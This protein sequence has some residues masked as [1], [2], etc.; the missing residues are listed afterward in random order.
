MCTSN[1]HYYRVGIMV[2]KRA[3]IVRIQHKGLYLTPVDVKLMHT[4]TSKH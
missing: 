3:N 1:F 2:A 4:G